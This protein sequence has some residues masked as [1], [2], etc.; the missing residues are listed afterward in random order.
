MVDFSVKGANKRRTLTPDEL[1]PVKVFTLSES[2]K[3]STREV[4]VDMESFALVVAPV[5]GEFTGSLA[6]GEW[7]SSLASLVRL[8]AEHP[9]VE[10]GGL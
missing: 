6:K 3:R 7:Q 2:T 5:L 4:A 10:L 1:D 9:G 8:R